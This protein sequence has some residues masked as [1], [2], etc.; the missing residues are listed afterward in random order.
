MTSLVVKQ[1]CIANGVFF[2]TQSQICCLYRLAVFTK[3]EVNCSAKDFRLKL[4]N[5]G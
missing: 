2:Q 3:I 1:E 5:G 4:R